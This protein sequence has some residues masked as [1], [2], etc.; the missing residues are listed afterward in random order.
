V[1]RYI[2]GH[3]IAW[4]FFFFLFWNPI[5][6][7]ARVPET[8]KWSPKGSTVYA[9]KSRPRLRGCE[10]GKAVLSVCVMASM[11]GGRVRGTVLFTAS[12]LVRPII[13]PKHLIITN[14][15]MYET[16]LYQ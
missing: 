16:G 4:I 9:C 15:C 6:Y 1:E 2:L 7:T 14:R 12:G 11:D 8:Q 3:H 5:L 13:S 10:A